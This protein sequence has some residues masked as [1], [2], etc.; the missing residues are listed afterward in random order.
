[1]L[2]A[3]GWL[4]MLEYVQ[5]DCNLNKL[6]K[7]YSIR[8]HFIS[9]I[10]LQLMKMSKPK[11]NCSWLFAQWTSRMTRGCVD[12]INGSD[13]ND[14]ELNWAKWMLKNVE[15]Y[16]NDILM[17]ILKLN[18]GNWPNSTKPWTIGKWITKIDPKSCPASF[19]IS[20][21]FHAG[22]VINVRTYVFE[23]KLFWHCHLTRGRR[24]IIGKKEQKINRKCSNFS[25]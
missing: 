8:I 19:I 14:F 2:L 22:V 10:G 25:R 12:R 24:K 5:I 9:Q 23:W 16:E 15:K 18:S 1:M 20:F 7:Y 13:F 3:V 17:P 6:N 4:K 11:G 21:L